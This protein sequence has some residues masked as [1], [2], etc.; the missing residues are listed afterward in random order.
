[1]PVLTRT[2]PPRPGRA[3]RDG[4]RDDARDDAREHARATAT[5]LVVARHSGWRGAA[6]R[7]AG[8]VALG[9]WALA[10]TDASLGVLLTLLAGYAAFS[11]AAALVLAYRLG[12]AGL[13]AWPA[14]AYA[15]VAFVV[16]VALALWAA[17]MT[18]VMVTLFAAWMVVTGA[19]ELALAARW[20][21]LL[22]HAWPLVLTGVASL[23]FA[24]VLLAQPALAAHVAMRLVGAY[25]VLTGVFLLGMAF[26]LRRWHA[27]AAALLVD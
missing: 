19:A 16:V 15:L 11:G 26:R 12:R 4:A 14:A 6:L 27:A 18:A 3:A 23:S 2:A 1:M 7:G 13:R 21:A 17:P 9:V 25:A 10:W 5:L 24:W 22:P 8:A 20:R